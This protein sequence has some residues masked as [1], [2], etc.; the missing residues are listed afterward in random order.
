MRSPPLSQRRMSGVRLTHAKALMILL[1]NEGMRGCFIGC[2]NLGAVWRFT[3][4]RRGTHEPPSPKKV[5]FYASSHFVKVQREGRI[6]PWYFNFPS[7]YLEAIQL[8]PD[9]SLFPY[10]LVLRDVDGPIHS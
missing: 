6:E 8:K 1:K 4:L 2:L 3:L 7:N 5:V 10:Q 9:N